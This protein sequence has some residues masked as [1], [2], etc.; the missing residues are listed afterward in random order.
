MGWECPSLKRLRIACRAAGLAKAKI[1]ADAQRD[2]EQAEAIA[3]REAQRQHDHAL[4]ALAA[5]KIAT[6]A[7]A[8]GK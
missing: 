5:D 4:D 6:D 3:A 8:K 1:A 7:A 2:Q